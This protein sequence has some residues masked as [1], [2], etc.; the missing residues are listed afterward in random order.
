M[1]EKKVTDRKITRLSDF[2]EEE[3]KFYHQSM[4][5]FYATNPLKLKKVS[6]SETFDEHGFRYP[7]DHLKAM[8]I[9]VVSFPLEIMA[10]YCDR[11]TKLLV[12]E[13]DIDFLIN[14][15]Y[16]Y[17]FEQMDIRYLN[18]T[19]VGN[20]AYAC[21]HCKEQKARNILENQ[22]NKILSIA[23]NDINNKATFN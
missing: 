19:G 2:T 11:S 23:I 10:T 16:E 20:M 17:D 9:F 5:H 7:I 15:V 13:G 14:S 6:P 18:A 8:G 1:F 22:L 12:D 21:L 4:D 3:I